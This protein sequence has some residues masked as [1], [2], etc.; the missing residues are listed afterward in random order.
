VPKPN[1]APTPPRS[2]RRTGV[3]RRKVDK[4]PPAGM[5]DRRVHIEPRKPDVQEVEIS[6]SDWANLTGLP[7]PPAKPPKG[8]A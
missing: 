1:S 5:R 3:D 6:P 8:P 2:D 7:P 4:G